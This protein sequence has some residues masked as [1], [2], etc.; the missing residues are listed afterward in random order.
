MLARHHRLPL[1]LLLHEDLVDTPANTQ[2][3][4][5][6]SEELSNLDQADP[7]F[8]Y[9]MEMGGIFF[10]SNQGVDQKTQ[11]MVCCWVKAS[12]ISFTIGNIEVG[13]K[14]LLLESK[15]DKRCLLLVRIFCHQFM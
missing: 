12:K 5:T 2:S 11:E 1:R 7:T 8:L 15:V 10:R 6:Q 14:H 4:D 13:K 9:F 3:S